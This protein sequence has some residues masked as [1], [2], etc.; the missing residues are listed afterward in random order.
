M[1]MVE[2]NIPNEVD[3]PGESS[4]HLRRSA[5]DDHTWTAFEALDASVFEMVVQSRLK[6]MDEVL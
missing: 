1:T 4:D 2:M 6:E 5:C 3:K